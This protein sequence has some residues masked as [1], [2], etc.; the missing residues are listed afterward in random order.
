MIICVYK[1][2]C[3]WYK[4][5]CTASTS[6]GAFILQQGLERQH[7]DVGSW[8]MPHGSV[9]IHCTSTTPSVHPRLVPL[10]SVHQV[11]NQDTASCQRQ[12]QA[13]SL[14]HSIPAFAQRIV[15]GGNSKLNLSS[16]IP[17]FAQRKMY[18]CQCNLMLCSTGKPATWRRP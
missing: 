14:V 17:A 12:Q 16:H 9:H 4:L 18:R 2:M 15:K 3:Q 5:P 13:E 8:R 10:G 6:T 11:N 7:I 1:P